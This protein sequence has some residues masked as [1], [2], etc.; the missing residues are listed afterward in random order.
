MLEMVKAFSKAVGR[1]LPY[2]VVGRRTGDVLNLTANPKKANEELRWNAEKSLEE[3][4]E[5][6]WRWTER[7]PLGYRQSPP[8][9]LLDKLKAGAT[10][11]VP[12]LKGG[13]KDTVAT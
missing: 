10:P 9:D 4:C 3:A 7:N 6:L 1:D 8:Q 2:E 13:E 12:K 11:P 5:D